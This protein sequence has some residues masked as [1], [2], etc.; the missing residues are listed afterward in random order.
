MALVAGGLVVLP[1][2]TARAGVVQAT[3]V[4]QTWTG[5]PNSNWTHPSPDPSG[6]TYNSRTGQLIISDGEVEETGPAY[7]NNVWKGTNLFYASLSG[8]LLATGRNTMAYSPEPTG[9]G[10]RPTRVTSGYTWPERLFVSDDD[11]HRVFE[12]NAGSDGIYGNA[13]DTQTSFDVAF[14]DLGPE[15]DAEDV[16]V[17]LEATRNGQLLLIDGL[18]K[19]VFVY[20]P[21]PDRIFNGRAAQGHDDYVERV[22]DVSRFGAGDPEGI[23]Y[24]A[25]RN[26]MF[27]LDDPSNQI[28]EFGMNGSLLNIVTLPFKMGS[29]AGIAL[30]PPSNGTAGQNVYIVDRGVDNDTDQT[31]FN[32]GRLY[33]VAVPGLTG[34][35][36][37]APTVN[38]GPDRSVTLPGTASLAGTVTDDGLPNPPAATTATWSRV[39]GPGTVTFSPANSAAA[40]AGFSAAG[41]YVLRLTGSDGALPTSDDVTVTV[42]P[43]STNATVLDIPVRAGSDDAEQDGSSVDLKSSDVELVADG[44]TAQTVGL[45]FTGV[46]VP[47]GATITNAWVQ[48]QTDEVDTVATNLTVYGE[49]ADNATT[50]TTAASNV[51]T[52]A[53]TTASAAWAPPTWPTVGARTT[54]QRTPNLST[55]V[56]QI[57]N[58]TGWQ[59]GNALAL[60]ITGSG[61]RTAEA[62]ESGAASAPV[63]HVEYTAGSGGTTNAAPTVD[64]GAGSSVTMPDAATLS[65]TVTDDGL[66]DPPAATTATWSQVSGPG[67]VTF[68]PATTAATTAGFSAAGTYVLRL[69]GSDGSLST[70]DDVTVTVAA[71]PTG[72]T[73]G[74][75]DIPIRAGVDDAEQRGTSVNLSSGDLN[76]AVDSGRAQTIGMRF[77]GV[78]VPKGA[79]I[80]SAWVQFQADE[81]S[82][83]ASNLTVVGQAADS[84]LSFT[85]AASDI[86][87]RPRTTA[88]ATWSFADWPSA[89]A[90]TAAQ[91]TPNLA[92]V[93][94]EI[95]DRGGW[96]TGNPVALIVTGTGERIAESYNGGSAKAPVL[97]IE[98]TG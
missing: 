2:A 25:F 97:H 59:S 65:G 58:R 42:A 90:R 82:T 18:G 28:Y 32:D 77:T 96:A 72:G 68:S 51:S 57:V 37:T 81:V 73:S 22:F 98:W 52:R 14:L 47:K 56:Q 85:T 27:V 11:A 35:K 17:D 53:R 88:S 44:S 34:V 6:I 7:P 92:A 74:S 60:I 39:S 40:T 61:T 36:N 15:L 13:G 75:I 10:F 69:T 67:T 84:P 19:R 9:V 62:F 29:A 4:E 49:A 3:L 55:V 91:R 12:V 71:A 1:A 54:A 20:N 93:I 21:G 41:T 8:S 50:F 80:T 89:N 45:R 95:V 76:L 43:A 38:A 31:K 94:Q 70:S 78:N 23:A 33:E 48:F 66:P 5:G 30:A 64:A 79:R 63:L 16:A 24:N 87:S 83:G 86:S 46:S 26:T